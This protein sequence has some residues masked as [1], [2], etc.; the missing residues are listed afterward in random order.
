MPFGLSKYRDSIGVVGGVIFFSIS[1][2]IL[3]EVAVDFAG[4]TVF[5]QDSVQLKAILS[6]LLISVCYR[7]LKLESI[8]PFFPLILLPLSIFAS[9]PDYLVAHVAYITV[10]ATVYCVVLSSRDAVQDKKFFDIAA[11]F[12]LAWGIVLTEYFVNR[13]IVFPS[14][15]E[16]SGVFDYAHTE[17]ALLGRGDANQYLEMSVTTDTMISTSYRYPGFPFYLHWMFEL[18]GDNVRSILLLNVVYLAAAASFVAWIV[19]RKT[20]SKLI[21]FSVLW[22][23]LYLSSLPDFNANHQQL[24]VGPLH[25][26]VLLMHLFFLQKHVNSAKFSYLFYSLV[27]GFVLVSLRPNAAYYLLLLWPAILLYRYFADRS[28]LGLTSPTGVNSAKYYLVVS[29][30][31]VVMIASPLFY[32]MDYHSK[33]TGRFEVSAVQDHNLLYTA[34][35][36]LHAYRLGRPFTYAGGVPGDAE[37][38]AQYNEWKAQQPEGEPAHMGTFARQKI[39]EDF[40]T[41]TEVMWKAFQ[42]FIYPNAAWGTLFF[43]FV[44]G[45]VVS[46]FVVPKYM[47]VA[48]YSL[49]CLTTIPLVTG[50]YIEQ[51]RYN[52]HLL[53]PMIVLTVLAVVHLAYLVVGVIQRRIG[54]GN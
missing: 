4:L 43:M 38:L 19:R 2:A 13:S 29:F 53:Y 10:F 3:W 45:T 23:F 41:Y 47:L 15:A 6:F 18:F 12:I 14:L 37:V 8:Q 34:Y 44:V 30:M 39:T 32:Y 1:L 42:L 21:V 48:C 28:W 5:D 36:S 50:V 35:G 22:L 33:I 26:I 52:F 54:K 49:F 7:T 20:D 17:T 9:V 25:N 31:F 24:L 27:F 40:S 11:L 46:I 16:F 51:Y